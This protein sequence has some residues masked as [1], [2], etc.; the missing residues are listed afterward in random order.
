VAGM[1]EREG[2]QRERGARRAA[3][4]ALAPAGLSGERALREREGPQRER[5]ARRAGRP[6]APRG[7]AG[8]GTVPTGFS[9]E[10]V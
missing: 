6:A 2:P 4:P 7:G 3:R 8:I 5:G 9:E 10:R 1:S